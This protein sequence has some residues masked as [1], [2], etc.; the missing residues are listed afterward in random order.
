M[1]KAPFGLVNTRDI[2]G[3]STVKTIPGV[4][5]HIKTILNT[6]AVGGYQIKDM[7]KL[8]NELGL[9]T[10]SGK[11][12][13]LQYISKLLRQPLY[14]GLENNSLTGDEYVESLFPGII[15]PQTFY[16][17]QR[18]LSMKMSPK[19]RA[20]VTDNEQYPLRRFL[21]CAVCGESI[22]GSSPSSRGKRYPK[23]HCSHCKKSSIS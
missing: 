18:L 20:Y 5:Q 19:K 14:A 3:R 17:N 2:H 11:P 21:S 12:M 23:Y 22:R 4:T 16:Q 8:A 9:K 15:T 13:Y 1:H 6:F 7:V 10:S